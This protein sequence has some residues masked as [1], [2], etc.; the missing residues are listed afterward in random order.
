MPALSNIADASQLT[1]VQNCMLE[2]RTVNYW[3]F[4]AEE[5]RLPRDT[6]NVKLLTDKP[7]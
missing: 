1:A 4:F 2:A 6:N 3:D 5:T 7:L